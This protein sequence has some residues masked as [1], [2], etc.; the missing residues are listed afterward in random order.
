MG[1]SDDLQSGNTD[2]EEENK[3]KEKAGNA[4]GGGGKTAL[5]P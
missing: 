5:A 2:R 4:K 1:G 3:Y